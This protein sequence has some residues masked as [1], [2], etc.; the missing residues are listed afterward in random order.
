MLRNICWINWT[1]TV[2]WYFRNTN[3]QRWK[4]KY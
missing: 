2:Y 4:Q 1:V 3:S